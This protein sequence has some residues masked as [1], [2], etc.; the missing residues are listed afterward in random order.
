MVFFVLNSQAQGGDLM[1][2]TRQEEVLDPVAREDVLESVARQRLRRLRDDEAAE[3][4]E[5][6]LAVARRAQL[7][8]QE[9]AQ[10]IV[11]RLFADHVPNQEVL[12]E[13]LRRLDDVLHLEHARKALRRRVRH[14]RLPADVPNHRAEAVDDRLVPVDLV[15]CS[16]SIREG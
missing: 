5:H 11:D 1:W 3:Q 16:A 7:V 8:D 12:R 13:A 6:H 4:V 10:P 9:H 14:A 2:L 15:R